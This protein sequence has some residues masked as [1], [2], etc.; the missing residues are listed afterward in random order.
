MTLL[1]RFPDQTRRIHRIGNL[2]R[3]IGEARDR[4]R[5]VD[6]ERI[7]LRRQA[8]VE[9]VVAGDVQHVPAVGKVR[10]PR[11]PFDLFG[12]DV[13]DRLRRVDFVGGVERPRSG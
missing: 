5:A 7:D 8:R 9:I 3:L 11:Q 10:A 4:R 13:L 6:R 2:L 1:Q 12:D